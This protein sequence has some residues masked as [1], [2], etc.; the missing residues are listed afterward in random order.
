M[1]SYRSSYLPLPD[2]LAKKKAII[3]PKNSDRECFKWA[4]IAVLRWEEIGNNPERIS[5]LKR[6]EADFDWSGVGFPVFFRDIKGFESRNQISINILAVEVRQIYIC[7]KG[8]NYERIVNLMLITENNRKHYVAIISLSRLLSKQNSKHKERQYFCMNCLQGFKEEKSRNEHIGYCKDNESVRIEMP[9][10]RPI[11]EYS[12]GQFQFKVLFIMYADFGSILE[13]IQ[14]PG[15]NPKILTTRG[16]NVHVPSGW[17]V[18]SEFAYGEVKDPLKLYGGKDCNR[19]FCEHVIGEAHRLYHSF[20]EKPMEPLMKAQWKDYKCVSNCHICFKPFKE[21]NW[22]VRDHC[23]YSG[24]NRGVAHSLCNLQYK[25]PSYILVVFHNLTGYDTHM[26]IKELA[27]C[28][29]CMGVI[30]K[31]KEDYISFSVSVEVC[32]YI[33]KN[34]EERSEEID[35]RFINSLKFMSSSLDSLVNNQVRG[36]KKFFGFKDYNESQYKLLIQKGI[37]PYEYRYD[38]DKFA[39]TTSSKGSFL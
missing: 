12:D 15:N 33:D 11:V 5:K 8:G 14:G 13:L 31:S 29:L 3:N 20:P 23:H 17:C 28:G 22:K 19:K 37:Y 16:I 1:R 38:S 2:W 32:K 34:G 39:E 7:R 36:N 4:V 27:K 30:A 21:G 9:H 6:F 24:I 18:W 35:L 25:I 10:K 26:F